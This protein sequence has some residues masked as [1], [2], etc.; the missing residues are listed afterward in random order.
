[1]ITDEIDEFIEGE[2]SNYRFQADDVA[3]TDRE[4]LLA[5]ADAIEELLEKL[6]EQEFSI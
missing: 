4:R 5:I 6:C 1:M 3:G 2:I